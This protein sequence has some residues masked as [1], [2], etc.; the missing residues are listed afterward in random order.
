MQLKEEILHVGLRVSLYIEHPTEDLSSLSEKLGFPIFRIW[1]SGDQRKTPRGDLLEG[2]YT[3]SYS[4]IRLNDEDRDIID[5]IEEFLE[6]ANQYRTEFQALSE[7]GGYF[8]L[9]IFD[10]SDGRLAIVFE[11]EL[12]QRLA[13]MHFS[14]G[15][16]K[17]P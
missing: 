14:L 1:L 9:N 5:L 11:T 3:C 4:C 10:V 13:S 2:K 8:S 15:L 12:L 6:V 7:T 17:L 16:E